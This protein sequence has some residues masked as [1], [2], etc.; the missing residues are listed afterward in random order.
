MIDDIRCPQCGTVNSSFAR[1]MSLSRCRNCGCDL[2]LLE[3]SET[4]HQGGVLQGRSDLYEYRLSEEEAEFT[5]QGVLL[6]PGLRL[7]FQQGAL[8]ILGDA[9][10]NPGVS[11][12]WKRLKGDREQISFDA[13]RSV[14]IVYHLEILSRENHPYQHHW[15]IAL[16]LQDERRLPLGRITAERQFPG[17]LRSHHHALRLA[18]ALHELTGWPVRQQDLGEED[19]RKSPQ[20]Q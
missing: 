5:P 20:Q 8:L 17:P 13:I 19:H 4:L 3:V 2:Q 10:A 7:K 1:F 6:A 11:M 12:L 15:D 18:H 9:S 14:E 16:L